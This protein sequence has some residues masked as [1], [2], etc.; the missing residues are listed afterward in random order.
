MMKLVKIATTKESWKIY[1][2]FLEDYFK[3]K[4]ES[5]VMRDSIEDEIK[6][7]EQDRYKISGLAVF[8]PEQEDRVEA[9]KKLLNLDNRIAKMKSAIDNKKYD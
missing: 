7:L 2:R 4:A 8:N 1:D 5:Q 9:Q 6:E 3:T